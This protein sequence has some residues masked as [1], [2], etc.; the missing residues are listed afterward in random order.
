LKHF[1]DQVELTYEEIKYNWKY[2]INKNIHENKNIIEDELNNQKIRYKFSFY[3][4]CEKSLNIFNLMIGIL[5]NLII[6]FY[7]SGDCFFSSYL[8]KL[9][10]V[11]CLLMMFF[12]IGYLF[13]F[14]QEKFNFLVKM[15]LARLDISK[16]DVYKLNWHE[17]FDIYYVS[18]FYNHKSLILLINIF[19]PLFCLFYENGIVLFPLQLFTLILFVDTINEIVNA[20]ACRYDE[21]LAMIILLLILI[22]FYANIAFFFFPN[23][24]VIQLE[25]V[26]YS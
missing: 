9:I 15:E 22:I 4:N 11:A 25:D 16:R 6:I 2:K 12:N 5:I 23:E 1:L 17:R 8:Y 20:F 14:I 10:L 26:F 21:I 3:I 24:F 19:I 18:I 7:Y 13:K